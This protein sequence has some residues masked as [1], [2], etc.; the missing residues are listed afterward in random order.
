MDSRGTQNGGTVRAGDVYAV[1]LDDTHFGAVRVIRTQE[2]SDERTALVAVTPWYGNG[3]PAPD[4]PSLREVL[5]L[6]RG[7]FGGRAAVSWYSGNPPVDF[8]YIGSIN[9]SQ[10]EQHFD[11]QGT[12]SG[13]WSHAMAKDVVLELGLAYPH[14][15]QI[16][17]NE[18]NSADQDQVSGKMPEDEFWRAIDTINLQASTQEAMVEPLIIHLASLDPAKIAGFQRSLCEKLFRLDREELARE[19]GEYAYG[20]R[21][22]F[23][24]D[25]FL[26]V[27]AAV[28]AG[29]RDYYHRVLSNASLMPKDRDLELLTTV[30]E[31]AYKRRFGQTPVFVGVMNCET[32]GNKSGWK[33]PNR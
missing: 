19:I 21:A 18:V 23:S 2:D 30:A 3:I 10:E 33:S 29:G 31:A 32:F 26:D 24:V 28:V 4:E 15:S 5:K 6:K 1:P 20:S 16:R 27:R 7:R 13:Q 11:A 25:H 14:D 9:P 17:A 12:Y 22:G 8:V